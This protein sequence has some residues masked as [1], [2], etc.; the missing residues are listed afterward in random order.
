MTPEA[1]AHAGRAPV[2]GG[3]QT[4]EARTP[5]H[6]RPVLLVPAHRPPGA[7]HARSQHMS[8]RLR[9]LPR[10]HAGRRPGGWV[11]AVRT[12]QTPPALSRAEFGNHFRKRFADPAFHAEDPAIARLEE[13]A[14]G[15]NTGNRKAPR[16]RQAGPGYADPD[17][18]LSTEWLATRARI[19]DAQQRWSDPATP[20][21]V[22]LVCGSAR[23]DGSCPGE[24]S[25]TF[26][27]L[28]LASEVLLATGFRVDLLDLSLLTSDH[29]RHI[30]PCKACVST[31]M[32]LCH[33][34]CS[35]YP[36]HARDQTGDWMAEIHER[37][38]AAHA[39]IIAS[40]V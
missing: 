29:G 25:K 21:R 32:P 15:A 10:P 9:P 1:P 4:V 35:C 8:C 36:N 14:W 16:A 33:W 17:D 20:L 27:L 2:F 13:I 24:M 18:A 12:G 31:A 34:P 38:T 39:V 22:L 30:H 11:S 19:A 37:W 6:G 26:R 40:P 7:D 28:G 3:V 23:N 5:D